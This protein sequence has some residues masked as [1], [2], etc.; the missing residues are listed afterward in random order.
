M[1]KQETEHSEFKKTEDEETT[2]S[3]GIKTMR[4]EN[5]NEVLFRETG[6][7]M[8][9]QECDQCEGT[10][11][12]GTAISVTTTGKTVVIDMFALRHTCL[13]PLDPDRI[14]VLREG[15]DDPQA[16]GRRDEQ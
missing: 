8:D 4:D 11:R 9:P 15:I 13:K 14:S 3:R 12:N 7:S 6:L 5:G 10:V 16:R 1:E 2:D